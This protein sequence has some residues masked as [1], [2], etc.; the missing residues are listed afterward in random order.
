LE[1]LPTNKF[2]K[3]IIGLTIEGKNMTKE[4]R[5]KE[6][7]ARAKEIMEATLGGEKY[8]GKENPNNTSNNK[9]RPG[10]MDR[11]SGRAKDRH[12]RG[13]SAYLASRKAERS[14]TGHKAKRLAQKGDAAARVTPD[15]H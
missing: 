15:W 12:E 4:T 9:N 13:N 2:C 3:S 8:K 5:R 6:L 14:A 11:I 7:M 1:I 10:I